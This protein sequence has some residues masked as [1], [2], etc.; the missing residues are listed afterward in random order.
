MQKI[1]RVLMCVDMSD[2]SVDTVDF[3]LSLIKGLSA[4]VLIFSV[5]NSRDI[6]AVRTASHYYP[7]K[8]NVEHYIEEAKAERQQRLRQM[9]ESHFPQAMATM[10]VIIR[11]GNPAEEILQAVNREKIDLVVI[12]N[13]G[14][15]NISGTLFGSNAEKVFRHAPVPVVSVRSRERFS[16][17]G[18]GEQG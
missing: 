14:R 1:S 7:E 10:Q 16:R 9:L 13:K 11:L 15:S 18:R 4:E 3:G 8:I 17:S 2:Y 5:V 12:G 6:E